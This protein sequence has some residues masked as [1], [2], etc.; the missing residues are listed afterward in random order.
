MV[1]I[2]EL[3]LVQQVAVV[4]M[5]TLVGII[6]AFPADL[7]VLR[8]STQ[9]K[10]HRTLEEDHIS[11]IDLHQPHHTFGAFADGRSWFASILLIYQALGQGGGGLSSIPRFMT[12]CYALRIATISADAGACLQVPST[13]FSDNML[14]CFSHVFEVCD[15]IFH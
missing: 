9:Q 14:A 1:T 13:Y 10:M 4:R 8:H 7:S 11:S 15:I 2:D 3:S 6:S 5:I 12:A